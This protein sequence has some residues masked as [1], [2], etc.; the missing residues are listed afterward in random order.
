MDVSRYWCSVTCNRHFHFSI[1]GQ[2]SGFKFIAH[3]KPLSDSPVFSFRFFCNVSFG[4]VFCFFQSHSHNTLFTSCMLSSVWMFALV[5]CLFSFKN[6][7]TVFT[8]VFLLELIAIW[9]CLNKLCMWVTTQLCLVS[10]ILLSVHF[11]YWLS[12]TL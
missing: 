4:H 6:H 8:Q 7:I 2:C 12:S 10:L 5:T 9:I 1:F 11:V 3:A